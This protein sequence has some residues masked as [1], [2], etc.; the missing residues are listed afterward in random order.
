[1]A[2]ASSLRGVSS[3][4][5]QQQI[6]QKQEK[7]ETEAPEESAISKAGGLTEFILHHNFFGQ[8]LLNQVG[9][10]LRNDVYVRKLDLSNNRITNEKMI[11][12]GDFIQA[13]YANEA[14]L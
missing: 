4:S 10:V 9:R 5:G 3:K 6:K 13:L 8:N 14:V 12:E 1:M 11:L 2:W 7:G